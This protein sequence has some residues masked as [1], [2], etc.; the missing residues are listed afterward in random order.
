MVVELIIVTTRVGNRDGGGECW[1]WGESRGRMVTGGEDVGL[2][3]EEVG[4]MEAEATEVMV[5]TA[6]AGVERSNS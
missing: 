2:G 3:S 4:V 6:M 1:L 5:A